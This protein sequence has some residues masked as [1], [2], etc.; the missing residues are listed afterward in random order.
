MNVATVGAVEKPATVIQTLT[1]MG[2]PWPD[3]SEPQSSDRVWGEKMQGARVVSKGI[4]DLMYGKMVQLA[5][6]VPP[7]SSIKGARGGVTLPGSALHQCPL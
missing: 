3:N 5:T 6:K 4:E 1:M 7:L 2:W